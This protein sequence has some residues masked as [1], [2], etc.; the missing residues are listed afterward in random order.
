[1]V[2]KTQKSL[3]TTEFSKLAG[4][5]TATISK[6]LREGNLKGTK[7]SGRWMI[8]ADQLKSK[9]LLDLKQKERT[10]K[11]A[12]KQTVPKAPP[13][14]RTQ[15]EKKVRPDSGKTGIPE[16]KTKSPEKTF[17]ISEFSR[18]TF[19]T[20]YGVEMFLKTGRLKGSKDDQDQ[21]RVDAD[22]LDDP[23]IRHLIR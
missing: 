19:L 13:K 3:T 8:A 1:M 17:S 14:G 7:S 16:K 10:A 11:A 2:K 6:L 18:L 20:D 22:N 23:R 5:S 15:P 21:W 9:A 12:P 4:I